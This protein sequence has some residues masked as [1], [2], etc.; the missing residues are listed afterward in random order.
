MNPTTPEEQQLLPLVSNKLRSAIWITT[1]PKQQLL[2]LSL[3]QV[4]V[5]YNQ[6]LHNTQLI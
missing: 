2:R 3:K 4:R 1:I 5:G 6:I